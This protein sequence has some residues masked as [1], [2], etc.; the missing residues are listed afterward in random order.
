V[1]KLITDFY[2]AKKATGYR[3]PTCKLC[4]AE[5]AIPK[6]DKRRAYMAAY[7][8]ANPNSFREWYERNKEQQQARCRAWHASNRERRSEYNSSW[9]KSNKG[10]VNAL[11]AKRTHAKRRAIP[12]WADL[13][14][15]K[16]IYAEA[17]RIS[18]ETGV[19]H[20][21][22]HIYPIQSDLVCGL[23]CEANLRIIPGFQN[24][25]KKNKM[26]DLSEVA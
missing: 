22:D 13:V 25:S 14:K 23:H 18:R 15:I 19:K 26:P 8:R 24:Q 9:S 6:R 4:V 10:I 21:V 2:L 11:I 20:H 16:A 17:A 1:T 3:N 12:V 7:K 5:K